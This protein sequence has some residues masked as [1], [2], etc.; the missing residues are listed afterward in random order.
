MDTNWSPHGITGYNTLEQP[1]QATASMM[2]MIGVWQV[3]LHMVILRSL[4]WSFRSKV[5]VFLID[6]HTLS[7]EAKL[8]TQATLSYLRASIY[9]D[10]I[11]LISRADRETL[12][13]LPEFHQLLLFEALSHLCEITVHSAILPMFTE[14]SARSAIS[15]NVIQQSAEQVIQHSDQL[16][17]LLKFYIDVGCDTTRLC[18]LIGYCA[19]A[20]GTALLMFEISSRQGSTSE[21][22]NGSGIDNSRVVKIQAMITLLDTLRSYW[23]TLECPVSRCYITRRYYHDLIHKASC[24]NILPFSG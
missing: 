24:A 12:E 3:L 23:K 6:R 21:Q 9:G 14:P 16:A 11:S 20:A 22:H 18:S 19:F 4:T 10:T 8:E 5:Q 2:K 7:P 13:S 17:S 1:L 15:V